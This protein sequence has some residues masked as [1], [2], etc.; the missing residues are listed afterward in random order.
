MPEITLAQIENEVRAER[1][2]ALRSQIR[3]E[4]KRRHRTEGHTPHEI[5]LLKVKAITYTDETGDTA[6][7]IRS[8]R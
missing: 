2:D 6:V 8:P 4:A 7:G 3:K 5:A 1:P